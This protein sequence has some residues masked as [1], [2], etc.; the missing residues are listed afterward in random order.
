MP[1]LFFAL[2]AVLIITEVYQARRREKEKNRAFSFFLA[3]QKSMGAEKCSAV[4][5]F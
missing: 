5:P 3:A 2:L 1:S 4:L